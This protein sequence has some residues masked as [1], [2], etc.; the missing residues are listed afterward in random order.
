MFWHTENRADRRRRLVA[1]ALRRIVADGTRPRQPIRGLEPIVRPSVAVACTPALERIAR[2]LE[3]PAAEI[4]ESTLSSL[5]TL[6][7]DGV[8]SPLYGHDPHAAAAAVRELSARLEPAPGTMSRTAE[9]KT[10]AL[11][12]TA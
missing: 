10:P 7:T 3:T 1:H 11:R 5:Y 8:T 12:A 6:V 4:A 2:V 9:V